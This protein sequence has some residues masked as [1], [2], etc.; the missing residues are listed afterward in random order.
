MYFIR[1][2]LF[3]LKDTTY[4]STSLFTDERMRQRLKMVEEFD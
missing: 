2:S 1:M 4:P 3:F